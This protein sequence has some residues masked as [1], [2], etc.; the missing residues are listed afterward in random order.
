MDSH[1]KPDDAPP[2]EPLQAWAF[3][4]RDGWT[5]VPEPAVCRVGEDGEKALHDAHYTEFV[6]W[7]HRDATRP[8]NRRPAMSTNGSSIPRM[9]EKET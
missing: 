8:R 9:E 2:A 4:H 7:P 5:R 6:A 3:S 1:T